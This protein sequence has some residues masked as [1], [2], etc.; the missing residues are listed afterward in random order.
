MPFA[1]TV[2]VES[3][4]VPTAVVVTV[5]VATDWPAAT[6]TVAGTVVAVPV[7]LTATTKPPTG[8]GPVIV[9]DAVLELPPIT[10][11]GVNV[12]PSTVARF[13]AN[14]ADLVTP[15]ADALTVA[16]TFAETDNVVAVAPALTA[17][18]GT[19]IDAGTPTAALFDDSATA[20]P[21][22]GAGPANVTVT[23]ADVPPMTE[24]GFTTTDSTA[25]RRTVTCADFDVPFADAAMETT[26]SATTAAVVTSNVADVALRGTVIV[27]GTTAEAE[28]DAKATV[29][30]PSGAGPVSV[31]VP[32]ALLP[33]VTL[34]GAI[35]TAET[36][37]RVIV[38]TPDLLKPFAV[39]VTDTDV[40]DDTAAVVTANVAVV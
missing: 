24:P 13:T 29:K 4:S 12:I 25:L 7:L 21:P 22:A 5:N 23:S 16:V 17:P 11:D 28:S 37:L 15:F 3:E 38:N 1:D 39:A 2:I 36:P 26:R 27:A 6:V 8:A 20:K 10:D 35:A 14:G 40:S 33:P 19:V 18:S 30:P 34:D 9:T 32:V 31:T